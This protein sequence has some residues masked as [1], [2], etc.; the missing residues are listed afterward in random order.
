MTKKSVTK[1]PKETKSA[2][3][4][5]LENLTKKDESRIDK[6]KTLVPEG[7]S[8]AVYLDL[9]KTQVLG[10]DRQKNERPDEDLMLFLYTCKRTGLDPLVRQIYAVYRWDSRLG[11][12]K[13]TIQSG[14]DGFRL[15]AQRTGDYAGQ[16][17]AKFTPEDESTK[18]PIKAEV[19]VYKM[20]KGARVPFVATA[21]WSEYATFGKEGKPEFMW[22]KMPYLMLAKCAESLAL[23]K[24]FPN[25]LS[26]IY[27]D[28]EMQQTT[29]MLGDLPT[30]DRF[31]KDETVTVDHGAPDDDTRPEMKK[32][33]E[34]TKAEKPSDDAKEVTKQN[35]PKA[36]KGE[37]VEPN[38]G[39]M[40]AKLKSENVSLG[41]NPSVAEMRTKIDKMKKRAKKKK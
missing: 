5:V 24:A 39:A 11:K 35:K 4:K 26:G 7:H 8:P 34:E 10:V 37:Q 36:A 12:D 21:R 25:E 22:E 41:A 18:Y 38:L 40:R 15:V 27:S 23:R 13:M 32:A 19:T 31:K 33:P 20:V 3:T 14:I 28:V 16:D 6:L 29:N 2:S 17:D 30:P 1:K 9:I